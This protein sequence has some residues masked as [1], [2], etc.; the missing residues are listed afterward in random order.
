MNPTRALPQRLFRRVR[1]AAEPDAALSLRCRDARIKKRMRQAEVAKVLGVG[2]SVYGLFERGEAALS[3][4]VLDRVKALL[5]DP[6]G[7]TP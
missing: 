7:G 4:E 5:F 1:S 2:G 3:A 6:A